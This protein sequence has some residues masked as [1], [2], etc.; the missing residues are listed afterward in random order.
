MFK[1]ITVLLLLVYRAESLSAQDI[2][3]FF[4]TLPASYTNELS[5]K[6]RDSILQGKSYYPASNDSEEVRVYKL[7]EVDLKKSWL[8][9]EMNYESGQRA[10]ETIELR[11]FKTKNGNSIVVFSD[12]SGVPHQSWQNNLS[13]LSYT[14]DKELTKSPSLGLIT[15]V[16]IKDFLKPNTPDSIIKKYEGYF[17]VNYELGLT[18]NNITL[19]LYGELYLEDFYKWLLG[20]TIEFLWKDDLFIKQKPIFNE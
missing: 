1:K 20:D 14:K 9:I 16:S 4:K 18:S 8:R 11:S 13:V 12:F 15:K 7:Q 10:F 3:Y 17:S 2:K 19:N 5:A 6:T